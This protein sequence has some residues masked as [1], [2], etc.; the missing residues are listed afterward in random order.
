MALS[1]K[2]QTFRQ[3]A[4]QPGFDDLVLRRRDVVFHPPLFDHVFIDVVNAV[5]RAP[6]AV[7]RLPHAAGVD[8]IFFGR[9]DHELVDL[10]AFDAVVADE[11][12]G[13]VGVSEKANGGVL[14]GKARGRIER[15]ED[16]SPLLRC[17]E[18]GVDDREIADL[19]R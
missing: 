9:L 1:A 3:E 4:R 12:A 13:Y 17:I 7:P 14:I 5:G 16:V 8:E 6:I 10:H 11:G 15:V 18:S 2:F 19:P